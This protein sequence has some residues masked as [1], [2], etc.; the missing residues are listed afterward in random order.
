MRR[1]SA[2]IL[3]QIRPALSRNALSSAA[4]PSGGS[5]VAAG[6]AVASVVV[7]GFSCMRATRHRTR[8]AGEATRSGASANVGLA[9]TARLAVGEGPQPKE[10]GQPGVRSPGLTCQNLAMLVTL[11]PGVDRDHVLELLR[12]A[13]ITITNNHGNMDRYGQWVTDNARMLR[14]QIARSD[15][16]Q[17]LFT[18]AFY[19]L[20]DPAMRGTPHGLQLLEDEIAERQTM[21]T[22]AFE[23]LRNQITA[24]NTA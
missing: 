7:T 22:A 20:V 12:S 11:T 24:W 6:S 3:S 2:A 18:Q 19:R 15:L 10:T 16:D 14:G 21:F 1:Y 13:S 17:L 8:V 5:A 4:S 23:K 9:V